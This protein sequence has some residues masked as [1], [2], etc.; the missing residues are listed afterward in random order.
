MELNNLLNTIGLT[1]DIVGVIL[2]FKYGLP[3]DLNK[4]GN[5][6]KA[7]EGTNFDEVKKYKK[8]NCWS[9]IALGLVITGFTLQIASNVIFS[10]SEKLTEF[11]V[12][13][14]NYNS[15]VTLFSDSTFC[16][17]RNFKGTISN[18]SGSWTG[19]IAKDST[20]TTSAEMV[21]LNIITLTPTSTYRFKSTGVEIESNSA[22]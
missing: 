15:S 13:T 21:G 4:H 11:Q 22:K 1:I 18:Y 14:S 16:E 7:L 17:K 2:L 5:I 20:I 3:S 19:V 12:Y 6:Y 9:R 10:S 8:Y